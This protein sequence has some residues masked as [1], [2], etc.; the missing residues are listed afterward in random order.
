MIGCF[1]TAGC[2]RKNS[3]EERAKIVEASVE[4]AIYG[5]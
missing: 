5:V 3:S 2:N 4:R 1:T